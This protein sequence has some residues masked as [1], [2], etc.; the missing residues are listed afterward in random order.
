MSS[1]PLVLGAMV[2]MAYN[3]G[4]MRPIWISAKMAEI[5]LC[6]ILGDN[7][8]AHTTAANERKCITLLLTHSSTHRK[9][10]QLF[11]LSAF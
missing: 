4:V 6:S 2:L 9:S 1:Q 3:G 8:I 7:K 5:F 11:V 10:E